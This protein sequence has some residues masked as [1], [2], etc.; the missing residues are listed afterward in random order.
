MTLYPFNRIVSLILVN[1]NFSKRIFFLENLNSIFS[2]I[3]YSLAKQAKGLGGFKIARQ[4]LESI[5][6]LRVPTHFQ[7]SRPILELLRLYN[8][9][10]KRPSNRSR[11]L[12]TWP[13]SWSK[14]N[15]ITIMQSCWSCVIDVHLITHWLSHQ[16]PLVATFVWNVNNR[17]CSLS[18]HLVRST[19]I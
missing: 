4:A 3:L 18:L 19:S 15:L 14:R 12:W 16:R 1:S 11:N 17:L 13:Q 10:L 8:Y 7:V 9:S 5:Q 2:A 6:N